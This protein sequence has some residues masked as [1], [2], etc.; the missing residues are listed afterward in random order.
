[1]SENNTEE[2]VEQEDAVQE[3]VKRNE[4]KVDE[5]E[6]LK[7]ELAEANDKYLRLYA[8]FDNYRRRTR[9]EQ[10]DLRLLAGE[11]VLTSFLPVVDDF[12][13]AFENTENTDV[14]L[15]GVKIINDK[16]IQIL[17]SNGVTKIEVKCGDAFDDNIHEAIVRQKTEDEKMKGKVVGIIENGYTMHGKVVRFVKVIIG[18]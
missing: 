6:K 9:Q 11:K 2:K 1:M 10:N 14:F 18:D 4:E 16:F 3:E 5:V 15:Q 12:A 7:N 17:T 13:R 8:E